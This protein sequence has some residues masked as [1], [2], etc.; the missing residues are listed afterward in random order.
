MTSDGTAPGTAPVYPGAGGVL[1][2]PLFGRDRELGAVAEL[3]GRLGRGAGGALVISGDAGMGKSAL[4][5]AA[6]AQARESGAR[7]LSASGVQSE[8]RLPFAGLHQLL[9]PVLPQAERL[10][11]RQRAALLSAF[12]MSDEAPPELFL[13]GLATLELISDTAEGSPVLVVI[14]D[15]HWVD[16]PSCS[17]F[18]F[19]ARRLAAESAVML[20]AVREGPASLF[21]EADLPELRLA[22]L[23]EDAAGELLDSVSPGLETVLRGRLIAEAAGNPLALVELPAAVRSA[24]LA[25]GPLVPSRLPLTARL[26]RAFAAQGSGLPAATRSALLA[27]AA[28]DGSVLREV[29]DAASALEGTRVTVDALAPAVAARLVEIQGTE[30]RF[31]HPLV[32]SAIYQAASVSARQAAHTALAALLLDQPDRRAWH[33]A[34]AALGPDDLAAADLDA[35]AERAYRRG[36]VA[37]AIDALRRAAQLSEDPASQGRR[38]LRAAELAFEVGRA[39]LG[40]EL[41][42]AAEPLDLPSDERTWVSFM[43]E[44]FAGAGWSGVAKLDSFVGLAE[45]MRA[46]GHADMAVQALWAI[47]IRCYWGNP[48][49]QTR[50]AVVAAAERLPLPENNPSLIAVLASADPVQCGAVVNG[51]ISRIAP[52]ASDPAGMLLIGYAATAVWAWDRSLAFLDVAVDGL[53]PQGR[54]I[55]LA[56]ALVSQ[57]WAGMHLAREPLATAAAGEASRLARE[58]DQLRWAI[59]AELAQAAVAAERG[60]V[61]AAEAIMRQ[62][63]A[64][65]LPMGAN[66]LLA[67]VQFA[68]GR[69]A[70][71]QQRY[72]E[73]FSHLRRILDPADPAYHPFV[74]T[75]GLA[76]LVEAAIH[77]G[78]TA[79]A[80]TYLRQLESLAETTAGPLLLAQAA[81]AR[82]LAAGDDAAE[83][84]YQA[85]L[86]YGL[87]NWPGYR[88]RMLLWYGGWLRRQRRAAESRAPLRAARDCFD[89]LGF[90]GLAEQARLELRA[91]GE[92]SSRRAPEAW[93]QLTSMELQIARMAADGMSN[94]EIGQQLYISHRTV[95]AHLYRIFPKL[96]ITSRSQLH[97]AISG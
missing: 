61:D 50:T 39:G 26:E 18:A 56:Q 42:Q 4:L 8:A 40:A 67:L 76:D 72:P 83:V 88:G 92:S 91:A 68:R 31:R 79:A 95:S 93:D 25:G 64:V 44:A 82:P 37:V 43:R 17:V 6:A 23:A 10:P 87:T 36:G 27:G 66:P 22:G 41:L 49:Q 28:D 53:R 59:A 20:V 57:A 33:R 48:S 51:R 30:L 62:A 38:L 81:Y 60:D 80:A 11:A 21:D 55:S 2:Y 52:D 85:A 24:Q 9:R 45:R 77:G 54:V 34:A 94:R 15:A 97:A 70:V 74:G 32:R 69:G 14:E 16:E 65:L 84:L 29:L 47:A 75:W 89:A 46:A 5:Q 1:A 7:V 86:E 3:V 35:A 12:G 19:V 90:R 63:E 13:V 58:T 78:D 71:V 73:G 96:G